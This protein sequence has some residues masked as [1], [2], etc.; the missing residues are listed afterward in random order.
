MTRV[1]KLTDGAK[2]PITMCG[3][4]DGILWLRVKQ[5]I[6]LACRS[7]EDPQKTS[8]LV[9]TFDED[10]SRNVT[11]EGFTGLFHLTEYP[12]D[13]TVQVGLKKQG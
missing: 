10:K 13:G 7:F 4:A 12:D 5:T 9:D 11:Y 8:V 2:V 6:S 1:I 3:A